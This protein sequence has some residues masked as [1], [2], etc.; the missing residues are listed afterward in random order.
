MSFA[1]GTAN[2]YLD[3]LAALATFA[4]AN[5]WTILEQ[6]ESKLFMKGTGLAGIDEIYC[7]VEAFDDSASDY[8][9][10]ELYGAWTYRSGRPFYNMPKSAGNNIAFVYLWNSPIPYWIAATPR[11]IIL[12]AKIGTVFETIHLGLLDPVGTVT[13][14]PYPLL[15]AACGTTAAQNYSVTGDGNRNFWA[16]SGTSNGRLSIPGGYWSSVNSSTIP[17]VSTTYGLK[18]IIITSVDG[19]YLLDQLFCTDAAQATTFGAID[20]LFRV[21]GYNQASENIITVSGVNFL[22]IQDVYRVGVGDFC[23]LRMD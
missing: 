1:S 14:Y 21:S 15:V 4:S 11:R 6:S 3:L 12:V 8:Y 16:N 10:W 2:N 19:E 20:G 17:V 18:D 22:V 7:G 9:N 23:A 13:Q 5:G